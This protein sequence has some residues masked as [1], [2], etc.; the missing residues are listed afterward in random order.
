MRLTLKDVLQ[1]TSGTLLA[2]GSG[3]AGADILGVSTDTRTLRAG[4]LFV[5][6]RGPHADGHEFVAD[7][8]ARGASAALVS[9]AVR[10]LPDG[11]PI[12]L[13]PDALAALAALA[14]AY[15]ATLDVTVVGITG[16]VGKTTTAALCADVLGRAYTVARTKDEWNAEIGVPLTV[17]GLD[18]RTQVAVIEMA[19]RGVGQIADLVS[20]AQPQIGVVT[21]IG[22]SHLELLGTRENIARA[23]GE[24][25][26]GLPPDGAAV[27]NADDPAVLA[28]AA[29]ARAR[30][31]TYGLDRPADV[32]AT[33]VAFT[34]GGMRFRLDAHDAGTAEVEIP[35]WGRHN[36]RNALAA[37]AVGFVLGMD[38]ERVAD[39][40]R[41]ARLPKM[42]LQPVRCGDV[43]VINDAYNASPSS[44]DAA[45]EV[46]EA[47]AHGRRAVAVL[48][49]MR[50]LGEVSPSLHREVGRR[51]AQRPVAL[52]LTVERGGDQIAQGAIDGGLPAECVV[53]ARTVEEAARTLPDLLRPGDVVLVKGSRALV[54]ERI[55]EA[56][57]QR[58]VL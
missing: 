43:L 22:E 11:G 12:V 13:V 38:R 32:A 24:L 16:S 53:R 3:P 5:A 18:E 15:R 30:V 45:F 1:A 2:A 56:L 27:L 19:M 52:L 7:A 35:A 8:F 33:D 23:K 46:L 6:L 37:A 17:L 57:Q 28:L 20:I 58:F 26:E 41:T 51:L 39:G 54:M 10:G 44:M 42:R 25:I 31:V 47:V 21:A 14:R 29:R 36:V 50:E 49:D 55:V 40:L 9:H 34:A 4:D 48:G